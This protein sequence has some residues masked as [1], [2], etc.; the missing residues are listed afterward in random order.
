M[1]CVIFE[2]KHPFFF[3]FLVC[4]IRKTP[5]I[6]WMLTALQLLVLGN[7]AHQGKKAADKI[8]LNMS[9]GEK[10]KTVQQV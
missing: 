7:A 1:V 4:S 3:F 2:K 8:V 5:L 10:T 9:S 6:V